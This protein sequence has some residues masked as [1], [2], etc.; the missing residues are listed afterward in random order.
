MRMCRRRSVGNAFGADRVAIWP[1][2]VPRGGIEPPTRG[3]SVHCSTPELPR[4]V[5]PGKARRGYFISI[6]L[7]TNPGL[8]FT[9]GAS[10]LERRGL[11]LSAG[12][13]WT[14]KV[15]CSDLQALGSMPRRAGPWSCSTAAAIRQ[16][17][18]S[19]LAGAIEL[20][21]NSAGAGCAADRLS[22]LSTRAVAAFA[23]RR[24]EFPLLDLGNRSGT[25]TAQRKR[26][27]G[28]PDQP[29]DLQTNRIE[30]PANFP[31]APL[32]QANCQP[33][34]C[35]RLMIQRHLKWA[36]FATV[37]AQTPF[38]YPHLRMPDSTPGT[39]AVAAEPSGGRHFHPLLQFSVVC[40]QQQSFGSQV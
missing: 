7:S 9:F 38:E 27:E 28:N 13:S 40:Q 26:T 36:Q 31:I 6:Q 33:C 35:I 32:A 29:A 16:K 11:A 17:F 12:T 3:F 19:C 18:S 10:R 1:D 24:L 5:M 23:Q 4:H 22:R 8:P 30:R 15:G 14:S 20:A 25:E 2:M 34:V 37:N 21:W 39:H